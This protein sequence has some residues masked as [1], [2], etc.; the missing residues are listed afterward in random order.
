[1]KPLDRSMFQAYRISSL[2][3]GKVYIG[4]TSRSLK[5]RWAEHLYESR[6]N[7]SRMTVTWAIAKHGADNFRI[8]P[9]CC[10]R[11]WDDICAA[12]QALIEQHGCTAPAGY[13]LRKGGDGAFG[14]KPTAE[15]IERSAAKHRGLPCHPNTRSASSRTHKGV[16]KS[17]AHRARIAAARRGIAR[18]EETKEKLRAYWAAR[19]AAG[20]FKTA[21]PYAH[22]KIPLALSQ[23]IAATYRPRF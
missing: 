12:E 16:K 21:K 13:N 3:D 14:R 18:S 5:A 17:P 22:A 1:V 11:S 10:A 23:H 15:A 20:E 6:R 19:R 8:E 9:I 4:I 2:I 7:R